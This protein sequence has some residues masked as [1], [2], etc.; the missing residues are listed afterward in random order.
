[1]VTTTGQKKLNRKDV[2][3]GTIRFILSFI[4]LTIVSFLSIFFFFKSSQLQN[5]ETRK[6]INEYHEMLER[7]N[8]LHMKMDTI[9]YKM[10]LI[11]NEKVANDNFL[12]QSI[13]SDMND[14]RE[15]IGKD[16]IG[17]LKNYATLLGNL[18]PVLDY[19]AK[20]GEL[21][22]KERNVKRMLDICS[23]KTSRVNAQM[24]R[25]SKPQLKGRLFNH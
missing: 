17:D 3:K 10:S 1:M 9:Y 20:L 6:Q 16:S 15:M 18:K 23:G 12:R 13:F 25:V 11:G 5:R 24:R 19:K 2:R 7:N 8:L 14:C 22:S 4:V 21:K